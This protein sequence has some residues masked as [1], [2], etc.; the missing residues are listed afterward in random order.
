MRLSPPR[1]H[2][3]PFHLPSCLHGPHLPAS[4]ESRTCPEVLFSSTSIVPRRGARRTPGTL[5]A[6]RLVNVD[7]CRF[8]VYGGLTSAHASAKTNGS[9]MLEST[10]RILTTHVGSLPRNET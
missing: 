5:L 6:A 2:R 4:V 9:A 8:R 7:G 3:M 1:R 10:D